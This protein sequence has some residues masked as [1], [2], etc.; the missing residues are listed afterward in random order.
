MWFIILGSQYVSMMKLAATLLIS[1]LLMA[2]ITVIAD[3]D[4]LAFAAKAVKKS[5]KHHH[6]HHVGNQVCDD[7]ICPGVPHNRPLR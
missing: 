3:T 1:M 7:K 6:V 5:P 4:Q 2:I